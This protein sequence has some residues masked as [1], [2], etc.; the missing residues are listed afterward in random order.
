MIIPLNIFL[1]MN[2]TSFHLSALSPTFSTWHVAAS[3]CCALRPRAPGL[4]HAGILLLFH[5]LRA[6]GALRPLMKERVTSFI[7]RHAAAY[8]RGLR[9]LQLTRLAFCTGGALIS[10]ASRRGSYPRA[11]I[12]WRAW[13][14]VNF[15]RSGNDFGDSWDGRGIPDALLWRGVIFTATLAAWDPT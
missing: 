11:L 10:L 5:A 7:Y 4:R 14:G 12:V 6:R 2:L 3:H 9:H 13:R 1:S 15:H 8:Y